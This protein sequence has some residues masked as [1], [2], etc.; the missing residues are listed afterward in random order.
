MGRE[1]LERLAR[2][3]SS[4]RAGAGDVDVPRG[5]LHLGRHRQAAAAGVEALPDID[6]NW[7]KIMSKGNETRNVVQYC[8]GNDVLKQLLPHMLEQLEVCQKALS[9]YLDQKRAAFPRFFFVSDA[10]LLEVLSQGSNPEAIQPHL[11]SVFDSIELHRGHR[12]QSRRQE[13]IA[14][15][16]SRRA[17]AEGQTCSSSTVV[18]AEGNIEDWLDRCSRRCRRRSTAS[19]R[20]RRRLRDAWASRLHAQVPGAGVAHR[21]PVQ[22][23]ARLRGRALPRQDGE[24]RDERDQ[25]EEPAAAQRPDRDQ[26]ADRPGARAVTASGRARRSRR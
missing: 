25:Q 16:R 5:R 10:V 23:D 3:S 15:L 2:S 13:V 1:A 6:K 18:K 8:Y 4:G 19:C 24:G 21:H 12:P 11:S 9:G 20:R 26:P 17:S 7:E 14:Q 22:V